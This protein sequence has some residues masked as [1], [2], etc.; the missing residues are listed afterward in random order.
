MYK[1]LLTI[2]LI[3]TLTG[4]STFTDEQL[5][6][7]HD[8]IIDACYTVMEY[9][10]ADKDTRILEYLQAKQDKG[11]ITINEKKIIIKC[12]IRT[13]KSNRWTK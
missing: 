3:L 6:T 1:L 2:P 7:R 11:H 4:C 8:G 10:P 13:Q 5:S 12:L 9:A